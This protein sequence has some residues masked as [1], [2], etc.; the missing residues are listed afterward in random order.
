MNP[1]KLGNNYLKGTYIDIFD[2]FDTDIHPIKY[3]LHLYN[4]MCFVYKVQTDIKLESFLTHL[5]DEYNLKDSDYVIKEEVAKTKKYK[6]V[7]Y[8]YGYYLI[9]I[10][11]KLLLEVTNYKLAFYYAKTLP[12][13]EI[14]TVIDLI[15]PHKKPK[16]HSSKF[17]MVAA[18]Q[19]SEYGFELE[20]FNIK[21]KKTDISLNYNDDFQSVNNTIIQFLRKKNQNGV[22]LLHGNYGT[23]KTTY[24]RHLMGVV[25]KRFIF[26]PTNLMR[27][28]SDPNFLPFM[29]KFQDSILVLE[30]CENLIK[31]RSNSDT[32]NTSLTNLL[33]LGDGLLADA[34]SIKIICTFNIDI[35]QIDPAILRKGRL[36]VRYEFKP[37]TPDKIKALSQKLGL[38]IDTNK[39]MTLADIYNKEHPDYSSDEQ[40]IGF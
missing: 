32:D 18:S 12:F 33:N 14:T 38:K 40:K 36:I 22:V 35:K 5:Q 8:D 9:I 25:N 3:F 21:G 28:I 1:E 17:Y 23:G 10:K 30:D 29:A 2:E 39:S 4:E 19:H 13:E 31:H 15:K 7:D 20:K 37:L 34:L 11:D 16:K 26:L 27:A 24:L 6:E